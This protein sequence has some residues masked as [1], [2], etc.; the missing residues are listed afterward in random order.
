MTTTTRKPRAPSH[1]RAGWL[2]KLA[3]FFIVA[4]W[5]IPSLGLLTNSFRTSVDS[6]TTGWW[7]SLLN[8][9]SSEWTLDNYNRVLTSGGLFDALIN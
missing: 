3:V 8:P 7:T 4:V 5:T 6:S 1:H 9:V 2:V